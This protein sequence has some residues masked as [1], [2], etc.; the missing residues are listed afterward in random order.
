MAHPELNELLNALLPFAQQMLGKNGEFFPFGADMKTDGEIEMIG[1]YEGQEHPKSQL[2]IDLMRE[3]FKKRAEN[4]EIRCAGIC[5]DVRI[6]PPGQTEK[7]DAICTS[8]E[9]QSGESI[10]VFL[11]YK[12]AILKKIRYGEI[13]ACPRKPEFFGNAPED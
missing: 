12:K 9:H 2:L 8:L 3:D 4:C 10:D 6:I 7:C 1:A 5:Y 13:F 11:P